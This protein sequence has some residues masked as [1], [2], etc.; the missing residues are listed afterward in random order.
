MAQTATSKGKRSQHPPLVREVYRDRYCVAFAWTSTEELEAAGWTI[1]RYPINPATGEF[2]DWPRRITFARDDSPR[3]NRQ[4]RE[5]ASNLPDQ[6]E[7]AESA[8]HTDS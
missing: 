6:E 7:V 1:R 8:D 2:A 5:N 4:R 3:D